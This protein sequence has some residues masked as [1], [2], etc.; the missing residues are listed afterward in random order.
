MQIM[1]IW[2]R[3]F[4][5]KGEDNEMLSLMYITNNPTVAS[6]AEAAGVDW[7]FID[8][9]W[10]GKTDRQGGM[11]TVQ[12]HHTIEDIRAIRAVVK[13][14]K[15]L[16]RCNPIHDSGS[17][18]G[19][20]EEEIEQISQAGADIIMLP[21]FKTV[22]EVQ[23]FIHAVDQRAK[24]LLLV[25]TPEA[26]ENLDDILKLEG[27]DYCHIGINDLHL[28]YHRKFMFEL[29]ADGTVEQICQKFDRA[30]VRYGFGGIARP[31]MGTLPAEKIIG[32]H[33]RL[34]STMAILSRTFYNQRL[35]RSEEE[36]KQYFAEAVE[37][38]REWEMRWQQAD[39]EEL[40]KNRASVCQSVDQIVEGM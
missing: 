31:G 9:E 30:G 19:S 11:D 25:E 10:I 1:K 29:L 6:A 37:E 4:P 20:S 36:M 21:Y 38:V 24:V 22:A 8:M 28:G 12:C 23:R 3:Q 16:V 15:V 14:S 17:E 27:I 39:K 13:K 33:V 5:S 40:E 34:G 2:E 35:K 7:I 26:V 18:Y 32:E